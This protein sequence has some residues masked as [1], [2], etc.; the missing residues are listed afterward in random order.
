MV[1]LPK[2]SEV[3][4]EQTRKLADIF[5][6]KEAWESEFNEVASIAGQAHQVQR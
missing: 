4:E 2:R 6:T 1:R 5:P 3:P